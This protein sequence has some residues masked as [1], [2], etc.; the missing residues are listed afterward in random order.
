VGWKSHGLRLSHSPQI[1]PQSI[2]ATA[3]QAASGEVRHLAADVGKWF[4]VR[5]EWRKIIFICWVGPVAWWASIRDRLLGCLYAVSST[6][7]RILPDMKM[8]NYW[9]KMGYHLNGLN[10]F[11]SGIP[12]LL[13]R[14]RLF[15]FLSHRFEWDFPSCFQA[16]IRVRSTTVVTDIYGVPLATKSHIISSECP[17]SLPSNGL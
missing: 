15:P 2:P 13:S 3:L 11:W 4:R 17:V 8:G 10:C 16:Y 1:P 7:N 9:I 6:K 12:F 5:I 14:F